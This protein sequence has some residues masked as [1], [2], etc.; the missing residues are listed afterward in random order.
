[1]KRTLT[2]GIILVLLLACTG[3]ASAFSNG[4]FET[5]VISP[6]SWTTF[7]N[8]YPGID[9]TVEQGLGAPN[10]ITPT[11]EIQTQ[12]AIGLAPFAGDQFAEL[13]SYANVNISQMISTTVGK[14]YL[15][16][17]AQACRSDGGENPSLLGV[18]W[19]DTYLGQTSCTA[20]NTWVPHTYSP[21]ASSTGS[22]KLM[23][24]DEGASNSFG[25]LLDGVTVTEEGNGVPVPEFPTVALPAA[26]I[27][28][29]IGA[30]L[31]IQ[32]SKEQ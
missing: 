31:F 15:I 4:G 10:D 6:T 2:I 32:K 20:T 27:I 19:G 23:F 30:V 9:W 21:I 11:L 18:Y 22:V 25:V 26:L 17:F 12:N 7:G 14:T 5:P 16:S 8:L 28:G 1:M 24:V 29:L 13:D 3:I